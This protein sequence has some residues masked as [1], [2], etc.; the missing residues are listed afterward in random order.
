MGTGQFT[1]GL[2]PSLSN[3]LA[4]LQS[5]AMDACTTG[6]SW[7]RSTQAY[8]TGARGA[9]SQSAQH[10]RSSCSLHCDPAPRPTAAM[11]AMKFCCNWNLPS[12]THRADSTTAAAPAPTATETPRPKGKVN[13]LPLNFFLQENPECLS[14]RYQTL[15]H[16]ALVKIPALCPCKKKKRYYHYQ[17][18]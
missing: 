7:W 2:S 4:I 1:W 12:R 10:T 18:P 3:H 15:L 6:D 8:G 13:V 14:W 11:N 9:I 16:T 17:N 5:I